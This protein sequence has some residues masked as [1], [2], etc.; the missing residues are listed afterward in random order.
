MQKKFLAIVALLAV[1]GCAQDYQPVVDLKGYD[2]GKYQKDLAECRQ[3]ASQVDVAGDSAVNGLIGAGVGAA[4]GAAVGA[5]AGVPAYG[6]A[7]GAA[8]GG[9]GG[10]GGSAVS[11]VERQKKIIDNCLTKRGYNVLG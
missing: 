3:L 8:L 7:S 5:V 9:I 6:A 10:G 2:G 1:A 4:L 11:K